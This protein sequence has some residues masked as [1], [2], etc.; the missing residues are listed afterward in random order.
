MEFFLVQHL[1]NI[2]EEPL[3]DRSRFINNF[4]QYIPQLVTRED[5]HNLNRPV[6]EEE[7]NEVINEMKNGKA[8]GLDGFNVD[9][10]NVCWKTVKQDILEVVE[11]SRRSKKVLKALNA[12]F[13]AFILKQGKAIT[14]DGLRPIALFNVV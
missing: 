14:L 4:T 7:V 9:L 10:F 5:N 6:S 2:A 13:I 12:S 1:L 3:V 11:D 8:P